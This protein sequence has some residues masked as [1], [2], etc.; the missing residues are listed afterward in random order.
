MQLKCGQLFSIA[1]LYNCIFSYYVE[2]EI[3]KCALY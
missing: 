1:V 2:E 3:R